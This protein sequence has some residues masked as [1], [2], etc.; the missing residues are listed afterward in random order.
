MVG[1]GGSSAGSYFAGPT[2]PILS[3]CASIVVTSTLRVTFMRVTLRPLNG[4]VLVH[5]R[6]W[7]H[8]YGAQFWHF[9]SFIQNLLVHHFYSTVIY[10]PRICKCMVYPYVP[11]QTT[12]Q[13]LNGYLI[14]LDWLPLDFTSDLVICKLGEEFDV[15]HGTECPDWD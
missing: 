4:Q 7:C 10:C 15:F 9:D 13:D 3:H 6:M 2:S 14:S 1:H 12:V 8:S 5:Q 11:I